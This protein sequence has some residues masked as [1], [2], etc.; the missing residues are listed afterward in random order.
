MNVPIKLFAAAAL[1]IAMPG[2]AG[3]Q[4]ETG[5]CPICIAEEP[6]GPLECARWV[7]GIDWCAS[8][9]GICVHGQE[10]CEGDPDDEELLLTAL[11]LSEEALMPGHF[12]LAL[13]PSAQDFSLPS[14]RLGV[15]R[16]V[17]RCDG[18]IVGHLASDHSGLH[19]QKQR[20]NGVN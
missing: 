15:D 19:R 3:A 18:M 16:F 2:N 13:H 8:V 1:V 12:I 20:A 6:G 11:V 17:R 10:Y 4:T 14:I 7:V 5:D 9:A